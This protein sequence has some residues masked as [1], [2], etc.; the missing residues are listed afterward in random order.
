MK[1]YN[2]E[3]KVTKYILVLKRTTKMYTDASNVDKMNTLRDAKKHFITNRTI[4]EI[5]K[6]F[7]N[8][9][10]TRITFIFL[11]IQKKN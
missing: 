1:S 11:G 9:N 3:V 4:K 5:N 7:F 8:L 6:L 2:N 10:P